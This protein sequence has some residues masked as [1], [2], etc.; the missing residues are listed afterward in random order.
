MYTLRLIDKETNV[1]NNH[2]LGTRYRVYHKEKS[3]KAFETVVKNYGIHHDSAFYA[4]VESELGFFSHVFDDQHA[5]I[6]T[7]SGKTF[8]RI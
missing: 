8:E 5:Y 6:M 7:E 4:I 2:S 3:P 1:E